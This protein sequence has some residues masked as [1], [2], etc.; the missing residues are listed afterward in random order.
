MGLAARAPG[1]ALHAPAATRSLRRNRDLGCSSTGDVFAVERKFEIFETAHLA[2]REI[3]ED[4]PA[5]P[6]AKMIEHGDWTVAPGSDVEDRIDRLARLPHY[7]CARRRYWRG[8]RR[9]HRG[10]VGRRRAR[11]GRRRLGWRFGPQFVAGV[12]IKAAV[13]TDQQ[14]DVEILQ[15]DP[16]RLDAPGQ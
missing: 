1:G 9:R 6:D 8:G 11:F 14:F 3:V 7:F 2:R 15:F 12:E 13:G 5:A 4:Q 16:R 10:L